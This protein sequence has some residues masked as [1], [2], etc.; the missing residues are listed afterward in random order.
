M[1]LSP[2]LAGLRTYP[3]L[4]LTEAKLRLA[5]QGVDFVDFGIGEPREE[6]PAFIREALAAA[7]EPLSTYPSSDGLPELRAA[8]AGWAERRFGVTL[9]A[10]SQIVPTLGSKEA[11]FGLAQAVGGELVAMGTPAYPV[12]ERGAAFAGKQLLEL[13]LREQA[14]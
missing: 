6:T 2:V 7:I 4:R 11:I 9:D 8:I 12:Y 14:G 13:P 10:D 3:F 1:K 5:A